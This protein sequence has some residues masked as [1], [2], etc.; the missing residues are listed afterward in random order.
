[1]IKKYR[2]KPTETIC[3]WHE[4]VGAY[5]GVSGQFLNFMIP[6][7]VVESGSDWEEIKEVPVK[8]LEQRVR[9]LEDRFGILKMYIKN[10]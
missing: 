3:E 5:Q 7:L 10:L 4:S 9:N 1:M 6:N 2:H 8:S